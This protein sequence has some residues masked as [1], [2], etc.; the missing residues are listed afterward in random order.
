MVLHICNPTRLE[1]Q[2]L[3]GLIT[4]QGYSGYIVSETLPPNKKEEQGM[5]LRG[6]AC[7]ES[8]GEVLGVWFNGP[9]WSCAFLA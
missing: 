1:V 4:S 6:R 5:F 2:A 9:I 7:L 3:S 8:A